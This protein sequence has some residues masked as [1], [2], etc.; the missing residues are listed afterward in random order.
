MVEAPIATS[1][2]LHSGAVP[3]PRKGTVFNRLES[4]GAIVGTTTGFS[5]AGS[6]PVNPGLPGTFPW[7]SGPAVA[8]NLYRFRSLKIRYM[9]ST[10]TTNTGVV[11]IAYNPDPNDPAPTNLAQ[12][13]NFDIRVRVSTW[14]DDWVEVPREELSRLPKYL[15]RNS[16]VPGEIATY[17]VGSIYVVCSGNASSVNTVGELWLEYEIELFS[18]IVGTGAAPKARGNSIY[19]GVMQ[20]ITTGVPTAITFP[21]IIDNALG[22]TNTA[23]TFTGITGAL[24][25]Y[26][27]VTISAAALTSGT[28]NILKNGVGVIGATYAAPLASLSTANVFGFVSLVPTDTLTVSVNLAG[29]TLVAAPGG[30]INAILVITPA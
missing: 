5:L 14:K 24:M 7:L 22:L 12:I 11:V 23:G 1:M 13:E 18:P 28:L 8:F 10:N 6:F 2:T 16:I 15:V 19:S 25:V 20:N 27:Q 9:N 17:D 30:A 26:A 4:L 3:R 21:T 29:T